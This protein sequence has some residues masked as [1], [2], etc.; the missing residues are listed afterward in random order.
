MSEPLEAFLASPAFRLVKDEKLRTAACQAADVYLAEHEPVKPNQFHAI[1]PTIQEGGLA[2]LERLAER[3]KSRTTNKKNEAFWRFLHGL[4]SQA[5]PAAKGGE[6]PYPTLYGLM[7]EELERKGILE[8]ENLPEAK[9]DKRKARK[10]NRQL[11][12]TAMEAA[13]AVYFEHFV[14]HCMYRRP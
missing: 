8:N 7:R 13:L 12:K 6:A 2:A 3:R 10:A 5:E 11:V 9:T 14:C 1:V 4:L